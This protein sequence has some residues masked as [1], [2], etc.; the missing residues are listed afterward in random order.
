[1]RARVRACVLQELV[2][3]LDSVSELNERM[4]VAFPPA[5]S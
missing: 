2:I 5:R 1:V 3:F 4:K